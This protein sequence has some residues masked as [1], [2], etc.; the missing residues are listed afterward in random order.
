[1]IGMLSA[2]INKALCECEQVFSHLGADHTTHIADVCKRRNG[3]CRI[4][5][6]HEG[7][8]LEVRP[9]HHCRDC[10]DVFSR[11]LPPTDTYIQRCELIGR[12]GHKEGV[13]YALGC[14]CCYGQ[15][16]FAG[17]CRLA[18]DRCVERHV[19][20]TRALY[21]KWMIVRVVFGADIGREVM[22]CCL[23]C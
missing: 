6:Y 7:S 23:G 3:K 21:S 1:M 8:L 16:Q 13:Y 17:S 10:A 14:L 12:M 9:V 11:A 4:I 20:E 5:F 19:R 18:C 15:T 22:R 2:E